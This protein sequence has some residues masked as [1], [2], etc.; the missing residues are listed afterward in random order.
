MIGSTTLGW[1]G[2]SS[3][4][5][6]VG[7]GCAALG[8]PE[9]PEALMQ[10]DGTP[11]PTSEL[12]GK[13]VLVVNV[14]SKCGLTPQYEQLQAV[15]EKYKDQ[16]L[17]VLGAPCNQFGSQE[18]GGPEEIQS[19]CKMNYGVTF[20]LLEKQNVNGKNRSPLYKF[21]IRRGTPVL[22]NFEKFLIGRDGKVITRFRSVTAPDSKKMIKAVETALAAGG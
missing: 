2:L 16:G 22:W 3:M 10:L 18:P 13:V 1:L 7:V 8:G 5:L 6:A 21:L 12:D 17:V 15:H 9:I 14:A 20:S 4:A 19:F 11:M